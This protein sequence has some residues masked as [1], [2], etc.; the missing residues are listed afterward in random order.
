Q[1]QSASADRP[2]QSPT[3]FKL[4]AKKR[5]QSQRGGFPVATTMMRMDVV[6]LHVLQVVLQVLQVVLAEARG[7]S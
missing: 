6:Q 3:G 7:G 1:L 2:C 4:L 5:S